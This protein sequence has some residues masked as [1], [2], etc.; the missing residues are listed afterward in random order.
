MSFKIGD[1]DSRSIPG[2]KAILKEVPSLNVSTSSEKLPVGSGSIY[3]RSTANSNSWNFS[4]ELSGNNVKDVL[5]KADVIS[6]HLNPMAH[7]M[8]DFIPDPYDPW[9]W[10]GVME[11]SIKWKRDKILWFDREGYCRMHGDLS[12]LT[13]DPYGYMVE[14]S[15]LLDGTGSSLTIN[16]SKGNAVTY[17]KITIEGALSASQ[18]W[19]FGDVKIRGPLQAGHKMVL[20]FAEMEFYIINSSGV[21]TKNMADQFVRFE[22]ISIPVGSTE[23]TTSVTGGLIVRVTVEITSR[24][25]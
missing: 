25:I 16:R 24:R 20:D 14:P 18:I 12:I 2:F 8:R 23:F 5:D 13:P 7:G 1:F 22:R 4:L 9:V 17:P 3:Y 11:G 19:S 15:V 10:Q 6:G 21:K